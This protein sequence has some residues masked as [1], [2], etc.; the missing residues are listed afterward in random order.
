MIVI[1]LTG[2]IGTGKSTA[3]QILSNL[4]AKVL[5]A[6]KVGHQLYQPGTPA[7]K[8]VVS[9]F[10]EGILK[11]NKEIDRGKLA[12]VVFKNHQALKRLNEIMHPKMFEEMKRILDKWRGEGVKV[13]VLEAAILFEANWTPLADEVWVVVADEEKVI[14]RL[15]R[16][17][18][19]TPDEVRRR[20]ASQMDVREKAKL[21]QVVLDNNG[22][23]NELR[24]QI[25]RQ[26]ERLGL[27]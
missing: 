16:N 8:E 10:G 1:G 25:E 3:S 15:C 17:K 22:D 23:I 9:A 14:E 21:A 2:G 11:P 7:W 27:T 24:K 18:G 26:W 5:D 20:L 4:G 12:Q 13:A 6:D 19:Y